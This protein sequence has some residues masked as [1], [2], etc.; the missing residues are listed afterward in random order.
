MNIIKKQ[1]AKDLSSKSISIL[2]GFRKALTDYE[3]VNQQIL[4]L[5]ND[6]AIKMAALNEEKELL[7]KTHEDN[8]KYI[9][10]INNFLN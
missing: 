9:N 8:E 2:D 7:V 3:R 6:V 1:T 4:Q 5:T 10:K